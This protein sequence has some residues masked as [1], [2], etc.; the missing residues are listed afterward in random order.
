MSLI[1][2]LEKIVGSNQVLANPENTKFNSD[3]TGE[4]NF[5]PKAVVRPRNVGQ[6]SKILELANNRKIPIVPS[7]GN[8]GLSGG[9]YADNAIILSLELMNDIREIRAVSKIAIVESGVI[10]SDLRNAVN[11][12]DLSFPLNFGAKSSAM[13]GGILSTNAGGSNVIKYGNAR[14]LCL[15]IEAVLPN[16]DIM[17]LMSELHKDNSGYNLK[18]LLIGAEGTLGIITAAVLKLH[19]KQKK[20]ATAL[21]AV[22]SIDAAISLLNRLQA[23]TGGAVEAFEYMPDTYLIK[24]L[25]LFPEARAPFSQNYKFNI[26][27]ELASSIESFTNQK[28]NSKVSLTDCLENVLQDCFSKEM[29]LDA[30]ISQNERQRQDMWKMREAAAEVI[31]SKKP[32]LNN[33]IAVPLDKIGSFLEVVSR[34]LAELDNGAESV[35]VAHLGDGNIHYTIW[36]QSL[37]TAVHYKTMEMVEEVVISLGGSFSAE[38]GIGKSKLG[39]MERLKNPVALKVMKTI[40]SSL[41]PNNILNPFKVI[42]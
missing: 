12:Q 23:V 27:I 29:V 17:N 34:R 42:P 30:V 7:G 1:F 33:D 40:K 31:I 26:L 14:D 6:I 32:L 19:P 13:I 3:W 41:D 10:L 38:H 16:G 9:T 39:S 21:A 25:S 28:P 24:Y 15:G 36:P 2:N 4:F 11:H 35:C 20:H 18:Q 37:D 8:T 22:E 5:R